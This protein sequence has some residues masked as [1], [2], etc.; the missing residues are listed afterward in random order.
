MIP[1]LRVRA[2]C[3]SVAAALVLFFSLPL[4]LR[5]D[6]VLKRSNELERAITALSVEVAELTEADHRALQRN[7]QAS[8]FAS[9]I[10]MSDEN[11]NKL[12]PQS[13]AAMKSWLLLAR[14]EYQ[15]QKMN[16]VLAPH[17]SLFESKVVFFN[18]IKTLTEIRL[19]MSSHYLASIILA[20]L[21]HELL[22]EAELTFFIEMLSAM[23]YELSTLGEPELLGELVGQMFEEISGAGAKVANELIENSLHLGVENKLNQFVELLENIILSTGGGGEVFVQVVRTAVEEKRLELTVLH[24]IPRKNA[25]AGRTTLISKVVALPFLLG[26]ITT[27]LVGAGVGAFG[28]LLI[29]HKLGVEIPKNVWITLPIMGVGLLMGM[30]TGGFIFDRILAPLSRAAG[31]RR[32]RRQGGVAIEKLTR[33]FTLLTSRGQGHDRGR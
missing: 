13:R 3:R 30:A 23:I 21:G 2:L 6:P 4:L 33:C 8:D 5:A 9:L 10:E 19:K 1:N 17:Q 12:S 28:P 11:L 29:S 24:K 25:T 18:K 16:S 14:A 22:A 26:S 32:V 20:G 31:H 15:Q 27:S 7:L